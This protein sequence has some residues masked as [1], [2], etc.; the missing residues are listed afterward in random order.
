[1]MAIGDSLYNG[2]RSLTINDELAQ[3]CAPALVAEGI[4]I[5]SS[6][7][8]PD[9]GR[10]MLIDLEKYLHMMPN[11]GGIKADIFA[12]FSH[13]INAP[14][15][16]SGLATF[17][18]LSIASTVYRDLTTRTAAT[19]EA[20]LAGMNAHQITDAQ[21]VIDHL[22]DLYFAL[23]TRFVLNPLGH[24]D[25]MDKSM[26]DIVEQR[27][28][29]TLLVNVGSN[30]GLWAM[31]FNC[32]TTRR[33]APTRGDLDALIDRLAAL[34]LDIHIYFNGLALPSTVANLMP[35]DY[36]ATV[37]RPPPDGYYDRY[38]N[39]FSTG[40]YGTIDRT[41]MKTLDTDV[42]NHN[43][44]TRDRIAATG[45]SRFHFVDV[46]AV[47]VRMNA[48]H[49][50][51][52]EINGLRMGDGRRF[53]NMML[54]AGPWPLPA[55]R[56]GGLQSLD[57]MHLSSLGYGLMAQAVLDTMGTGKT[58]NLEGVYQ[59]DRLLTNMPHVWAYVL[60]AWRDI[61]RA[62]AN[63]MPDITKA[64]HEEAKVAALMDA[65]AKFKIS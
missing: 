4:G 51:D 60:W 2:I 21:G 25:L 1:M 65:A 50:P 43:A 10:A 39:A 18:N 11:I 45:Q 23:N 42:R 57:G 58:V 48:K 52:T 38:E 9:Y 49:Q 24:D 44:Y 35:V 19:A 28:P 17:D 37:S 63:H 61:R 64:G 59:R 8:C 20:E 55:F 12:N 27:H 3:L 33:Y 6:F 41:Q 34:P 54:E 5:R 15:P 16:H 7:T 22:G 32:D 56:S 53:T 46:A 13:W 26:L 30:D 29:K 14:A 62:R 31:G 47:L 36:Y 40:S